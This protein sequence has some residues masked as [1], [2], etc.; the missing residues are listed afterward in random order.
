MDSAPGRGRDTHGRSN[1]KRSPTSRA[2]S[3]DD[4]YRRRSSRH[5][6]S[7]ADSSPSRHRSNRRGSGDTDGRV[8]GKQVIMKL[9]KALV[10]ERREK[11]AML[12]RSAAGD[13]TLLQPQGQVDTRPVIQ[14]ST[15][16]PTAVAA[17]AAAAHLTSPQ[18]P[19]PRMIAVAQPVAPPWFTTPQQHQQQ[20]V[21]HAMLPPKPS[22]MTVST[23]MPYRAP[24]PRTDSAAPLAVIPPAPPGTQ[25]A[26][27]PDMTSTA[28]SMMVSTQ[29]H[30]APPARSPHRMISPT[31]S[32]GVYAPQYAPQQLMPSIANAPFRTNATYF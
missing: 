5:R 9:L 29:Q 27:L 3:S 22:T 19:S 17:A 20:P 26:L 4:A 7:P 1:A 2:E 18:P 13:A 25:W 15:A 6:R 12:E 21:A 23:Q 32:Q 14:L 8:F 16:V 31:V 10:S 28:G 24:S 11:K 30:N